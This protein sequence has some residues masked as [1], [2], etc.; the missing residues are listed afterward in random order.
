MNGGTRS[1]VIIKPAKPP[2]IN[3]MPIPAVMA[4]KMPM[5]CWRENFSNRLAVA[6]PENATTDPTERSMPPVIITSVI[7]TA[8]IP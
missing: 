8:S 6:T 1:L 3:P 4:T 2:E 7:P 5:G